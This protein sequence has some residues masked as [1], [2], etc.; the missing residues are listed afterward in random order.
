MEQLLQL[1]IWIP[2]VGFF[3]SL[4]LPR[5]NEPLISGLVISVA[6]LHLLGAI[7]FLVYWLVNDHPVLNIKHIMLFAE[8]NTE[9]FID[10]YF[11]KI[12]AVFGIMG[13]VLVFL[14][15]IFSKY[16]MHR[17]EGFKRFFNVMLLFFFGY[18]IAV[19][20]GNFETLFIGWEF[21][22]ISSFLLI[23]FYRDRYLPVKN[24]L[25]VI[26]IYRLGDICLILAM[27]MSHHLWHENITFLK[28]NDFNAVAE[29]LNEHYWYG[30]FIALMIFIAAAAKSAQFP[31]SSWL[32]RAMEGPTASSAIFY[33]SL[34]VHLGVFLL[35]RT[36]PYWE[37]M[38]GIKILII[39]TGIVTSIIAS[40]I[41]KVQS[42][43]KT[44]IAYSSITQIGLIFI[45][46]ALGWHWLALIHFSGNAF[47]RTYQ[48]LV[49]PSVLSYLSH[50][51]FFNF[52]P[53][54]QNI[55][56]S[57]L[58]KIKNSLYMLSLKEWNMDAFMARFLWNPFKWLGKNL[59][60][61][62]SP[63]GI[64]FLVI[65]FAAGLYCNYFQ[66][67]IPPA[68]FEFSPYIVS[69]I[70]LMLILKAFA[71]RGDAM[72]AWS[73]VIAGQL[74]MTLSILL[75]NENFGHNHISLYFS[76]SVLS[77][78]VGYICLKKV[79]SLDNDIGLNQYHGYSHTHSGLG[80]IFLVACL[81]LV[82][83]PFT[84]TFIGIDLMFNHVHK[85]EELLIVFTSLNF[86]FIELAIIRIYSR[87]FLGQ[88]KKQ[89]HAM[90][91]RSS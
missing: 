54:K 88:Y 37:S 32:P 48:L 63:A 22:G 67:N 42:S 16:Y 53:K 90:A 69:F 51:M 31:F 61:L 24:G 66:E 87:I 44:Q 12:T 68:L 39:T 29:H 89:D 76:G 1:F 4:F 59:D 43:V 38:P 58:T 64:I 21:L 62:K 14:V 26:S 47:L 23:A 40:G 50:N 45:E 74:F 11:D 30:V 35:L 72:W 70:S 60:F 52:N 83:L 18:N 17:D 20:S 15:T 6:G 77:A 25:K 55:D 78:I 33:G 57:F 84:P 2:L 49:S 82:G 85:Y 80:F 34:S 71:E 13:S 3:V 86:V 75:L 36:Y 56:Q 91:F 46:I 81:G 27:W 19:Y 10:F 28:L 79:K 9:I 8:G 5:K 73:F 65:F 7:A 41:A